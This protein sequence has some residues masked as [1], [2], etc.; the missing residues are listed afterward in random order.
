MAG[1]PSIYSAEPAHPVLAHSLLARQERRRPDHDTT[2]T[3]AW[4]LQNDWDAGIQAFGNSVFHCGSVI[5][6]SRL[7]TKD[8]DSGEYVGQVRIKARFR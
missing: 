4:N 8:N 3:H 7:R 2:N 6:F 1:A 5:G